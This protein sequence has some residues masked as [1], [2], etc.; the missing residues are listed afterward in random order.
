ME[1]LNGTLTVWNKN[2]TFLFFSRIIKISADSFAFYSILWFLIFSGEGA[3]GT[4]LLIAVTFLP[5]ALLGPVTG[6]LMKRSTLKFWMYF[7]DLTRAV[8]VLSI[9]ICYFNGFSP[10]WFIL[11]LMIIYSATGATYHPASITLIPQI[12]HENFMQKANAIL[13]SS[14]EIAK[15]GTVTLCG[16]L[17]TLIGPATTL[18]ISFI[19]YIIS[20]IFVLCIKYQIEQ[21]SAVHETEKNRGT[22]KERLKRG[23]SLVRHHRILFPL[24]IYCIFMNLAA[25]PWEALSAVYV[26]EDLNATPFIHSLLK[27]TTTTGAFLLGLIL[28]KVKI[29]RYGLLFITAGIIEG[30]SFFITGLFTILPLVFI[31]AFVFGAAVSSINVP[32]YTIIQKTV[33]G[34]DQPQVFAII[35]MIGNFA[36]PLGSIVCGY[37]AVTFG[38]GKVIAFGGLI[39]LL[40]GLGILLFTKLAKAKESDLIKEKKASASI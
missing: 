21:Q 37:A 27:A 4:S 8:V 30:T 11:S 40:A 31:A 29:N 33:D 19:L 17:L 28:T 25:T 7:S 22:Y 3:I 14:S 9:P 10:M 32:E 36:F 1:K 39:E 12:I 6:P 24:A 26:S 34:D 16:F 5:E 13:Q 15:L 23:F 35:R 20:G 2:F 38:A 18:I